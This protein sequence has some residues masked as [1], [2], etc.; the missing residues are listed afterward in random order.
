MSRRAVAASALLVAAVFLA[1]A[2]AAADPEPAPAPVTPDLSKP[3]QLLSD[4]VVRTDGGSVLRLPPGRFLT[5]DLWGKLDAELRR[6]QTAEVRLT[7][8]NA[9][10]KASLS[11]GWQ[12]GWWTLLSVVAGAGATGWYLRGKL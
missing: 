6:L 10:Y 9:S 5:E 7:A 12:P 2:T 8:E 4:S 3:L 11:T 1:S